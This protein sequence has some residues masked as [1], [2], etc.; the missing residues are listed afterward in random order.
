MQ[1]VHKI[2]HTH[3]Q[4]N[5]HAH[6]TQHSCKYRFSDFPRGRSDVR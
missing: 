1:V 5:A 6:K 3:K 4:P 2:I